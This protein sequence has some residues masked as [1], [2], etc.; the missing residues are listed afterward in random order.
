MGAIL[1]HAWERW[2]LIGEINGDYLA[3]FVAFAFYFSIL[4]PF[5][6][7]A[8]LLIDPLELRKSARPHWLERKPV[9]VALDE[10]QSQS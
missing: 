10:A 8:R 6:L 2:R 9:G 1:R 3:R 4:V 7:I 5:A